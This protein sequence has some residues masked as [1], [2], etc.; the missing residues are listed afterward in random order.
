MLPALRLTHCSFTA[1]VLCIVVSNW[2]EIA[3]FASGA[4]KLRPYETVCVQVG[5]VAAKQMQHPRTHH[6]HSTTSDSL[7][8][9]ELDT[10]AARVG[11][12]VGFGSFG[13]DEHERPEAGLDRP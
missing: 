1:P 13:R 5:S 2:T 10:P 11:R 12:G 6:N 8:N 4:A 7:V 3:S 9:C